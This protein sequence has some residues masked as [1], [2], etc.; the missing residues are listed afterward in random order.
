MNSRCR[1]LVLLLAFVAQDLG[2]A[3]A[4]TKV[5][6]SIYKDAE[7]YTDTHVAIKFQGDKKLFFFAGPHKSASTSVEKFFA[8]W[9]KNGH[10][11]E[12][13]HT[14]PLGFW[15]WPQFDPDAGAKQ[16]G[17]L[18]KNKDDKDYLNKALDA[19]QT[20]FDDSDNGVFLGTEE[21]DQ[22]GPDK[23]LD[24]MP[25]MEAIVDRLKVDHK[26]IK[27]VIN[28]RTPRVEQWIS[29]WKHAG[30][31]YD[32]AS[33]SDF[34]CKAHGNEQDKKY[35]LSMIGAEMN[36]LGA[37]KIFL[38][39]GWQVALVDMGGVEKEGKHVVHTIGCD[40]LMAACDNGVIHSLQDYTPHKNAVE[41]DFNELNEE[42]TA[43]IEKLFQYRDCSYQ[44]DLQNYI[45]KG[46]MEV[47]YQD[48]LWADCGDNADYYKKFKDNTPML[49]NALLGQLE[50]K[51]NPHGL[52]V[53]S[54]MDAALNNVGGSGLGGGIFNFLFFFMVLVAAMGFAANQ[55]LQQRSKKRQEILAAG[56]DIMDD[57][58]GGVVTTTEMTDIGG[59]RD[60]ADLDE[61]EVS[62]QNPTIT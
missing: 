45:K 15:R 13:P 9:A 41:K 26:D 6:P 8:N 55:V 23:F 53:G 30:D 5:K 19:I 33:Y 39:R 43:K 2:P 48:S 21:F 3:E 49:Y 51:D 50:C 1:A 37:A 38:E 59:F 20:G 44:K 52:D 22:V 62:D 40:I 60:D 28:Y 4:Y 57:D 61:E 32:G 17:K 35:R 18:V 56:G 25:V 14:M 54:D 27:V 31:D 16:Y 10:V 12:H 29:V 42:E 11:P 58:E 46:Q 7:E 36:P 47:F 34:M 24:A